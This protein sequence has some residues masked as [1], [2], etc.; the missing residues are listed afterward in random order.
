ME[1][2]KNVF[3]TRGQC[4]YKI[5]NVFKLGIAEKFLYGRCKARIGRAG[6]CIA[7]GTWKAVCSVQEPWVAWLLVWAISSTAVKKMRAGEGLECAPE[8][9]TWVK[10]PAPSLSVLAWWTWGFLPCNTRVCCVFS[11][12]RTVV[13]SFFS[14]GICDFWTVIWWKI[15]CLN[16]VTK[17]SAALFSAATILIFTWDYFRNCCPHLCLVFVVVQPWD[18]FRC[19]VKN[20]YNW[21]GCEKQEPPVSHCSH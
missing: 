21:R 12:L 18:F 15:T 5:W 13:L 9:E 2:E 3:C 19:C 6:G 20:C 7:P 8:A 1:E 14:V 11:C 4:Q 10:A 17:M 16:T